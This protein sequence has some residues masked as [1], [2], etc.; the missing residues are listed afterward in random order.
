MK[1]PVEITSKTHRFIS[2]RVV[3]KKYTFEGGLKMYQEYYDFYK[4]FI[5]FAL[6]KKYEDFQRDY[7]LASSDCSKEELNEITGILIATSGDGTYRQYCIPINE[8]C[9][10]FFNYIIENVPCEYKVLKK[11]RGTYRDYG[12]TTWVREM[13]KTPE[14]YKGKI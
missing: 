2:I 12:P 7:F 14:K 1:R 13:N 5:E 8:N 11:T 9:D 3:P 6:N 4:K 10:K